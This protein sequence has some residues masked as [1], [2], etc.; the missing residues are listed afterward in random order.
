MEVLKT[1]LEF[2]QASQRLHAPVGLVPTMGALHRGHVSLLRQAK[3]E[4]S[5]VVVTIFV[6]PPQFG[7]REDIKKYPRPIEEDLALLQEEGVDLVFA[8]IT[9]EI[10]PHGFDTWVEVGALAHRLEGASRPGHFRG[11][12]TIVTK[13][14]NI[15]RPDRTYFGQKDAQQV[16]VIKRLNADLNLDAEIV[17][18]PTVRDPDGLACGSRNTSLSL[19]ERQAAPI[20][21]RSLQL[22][23]KMYAEGNGDAKE[24]RQAIIGMIDQEPL[25]NIDYVSVADAETLQELDNIDRPSLVSLAVYFGHTRLIDNISLGH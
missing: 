17:A 25:A 9:E 24:V 15:I 11:V 22:A 18:V 14:L 7:P 20:L 8:P 13:L 19:A 12:A 1:V 6:N 2:K 4:N 23:Q 21:F 10:Y 3:A 16:I 5:S